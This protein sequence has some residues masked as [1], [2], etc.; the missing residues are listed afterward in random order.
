MPSYHMHCGGVWDLTQ[1]Y[2]EQ[3]LAIE[4]LLPASPKEGYLLI[5]NLYPARD[6]TR[7]R[8]VQDR[9]CHYATAAT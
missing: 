5:K 9:L 3:K 8:C 1:V 6:Q 4:V 2:L 7:V